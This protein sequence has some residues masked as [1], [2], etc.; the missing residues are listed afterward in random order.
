MGNWDRSA[1]GAFTLVEVLV[2]ISIIGVLLGLL[3]PAAMRVREAANQTTCRNNLHNIGIALLTYD[4]TK[5]HLPPAYEFDEYFP[6]RLVVGEMQEYE[7]GEASKWEPMITAPGWGWGAFLLPYIEQ[8]AMADQFN[9]KKPIEHKYNEHIRKFVC[10]TYVCPSDRNT[11]IF[12]VL[13]QLNKPIGEFATNSYA[14]CYGTGGSIG[15]LPAKGDGLFYRNSKHKISKIPDGASTTLAIGERGAS[16][17][18][19]TW[20]GAISEA[21]VRSHPTAPIFHAAV[22]EP[23]TAVMAR[24]G[25]Y[26]LNSHYTEVY[27]FFSPHPATGNFVFA[28][29]A[30]RSISFTTKV[31]VW[32]ALA[33]RDGGE[34]LGGAEY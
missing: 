5:G 28:D 14:S 23:S 3:L 25:W 27:D 34:A 31:A 17:C 8:S 6:E 7:Y 19:A 1:R 12:L 18:Q 13:S 32:K 30:V 33:T 11:G 22:E 29:G 16:L 10:K 20:L 2:V 21:T 26:P 9:W 24:T 4:D 15:E